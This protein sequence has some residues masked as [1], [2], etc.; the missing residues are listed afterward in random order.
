MVLKDFFINFCILCTG[1]FLIHH[2][3]TKMSSESSIRKRICGGVLHGLFGVLLMKF[4]IQLNDGLL[5]DLRTIPMMIAAYVGGWVSILVATIIIII[6]RLTFYPISYS[7]LINVVVLTLSATAFTLITSSSMKVK[8]KWILMALSFIIIIGSIIQAI[9]PDF[10][11]ASIIFVQY[12]FAIVCATYGTYQLKSYLWRID[13]NYEKLTEFAQRD[14]LTGLNNARTFDVVINSAYVTAIERQDELSLI[15]IDIDYFKQVNDTY[16]H[17]A[18]D[19]VLKEIG[20][21][22][23][24]SCRSEDI[25]S[26]NGGEEFSIIMP[27]CD[28]TSA[29]KSA[30]RIRQSV[31]QSVFKINKDV[32]L[33]VTV[34]IGYSTLNQKNMI[35][36]GQ[37]IH[38]ADEGLYMAKQTGRNR[39]S[40][41]LHTV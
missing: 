17:P 24:Q 28:S 38:Q 4:G 26:R 1:I 18:G 10:T 35:S 5:I 29:K 9:I 19:E 8:K 37:L 2:F 41:Y 22:L 20:R 39:I 12:A 21:I 14:F 34:S 40:R 25:V 32:E 6:C 31:E 36:V 11:K 23:I 3:N 15:F 33:Q 27:A 13:D 16:G 7:S 30:E